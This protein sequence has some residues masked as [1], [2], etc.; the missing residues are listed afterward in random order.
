[1]FSCMVE[2]HNL[3]RIGEV[4]LNDM[5][6]PASPVPQDHDFS[7]SVHSTALGKRIKEAT[8]LFYRQPSCHI[9][10]GSG[11]IEKDAWHQFR[12]LTTGDAFKNRSHFD[13]SIDIG[14]A[15]GFS[16]FHGHASPA[17]AGRDSI[18]LNRQA[19]DGWAKDR[20]VLRCLRLFVSRLLKECLDLLF[21]LL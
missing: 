13:L 11:L 20:A 16:F 6:N 17:D 3:H 4:V 12:T 14:F 9:L 10:N 15:L 2:I 21:F 19:P 5:A 18:G 8:K 7:C 1:M